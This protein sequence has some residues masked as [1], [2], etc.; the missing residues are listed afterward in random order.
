ML[1]RAITAGGR[2]T[3]APDSRSG[4][5]N[6][7]DAVPSRPTSAIR[8]PRASHAGALPHCAPPT[9]PQITSS[10]PTIDGM[11]AVRLAPPVIM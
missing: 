2:V 8:P 7:A 4:T 11:S 6:S 10:A 1:A 3:G 9:A 5:R